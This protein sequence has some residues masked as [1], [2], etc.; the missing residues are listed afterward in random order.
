MLGYGFKP[1]STL[2]TSNSFDYST[3]QE[4]NEIEK[5]PIPNGNS[6]NISENGVDIS[7]DLADYSKASNNLEQLKVIRGLLNKLNDYNNQIQPVDINNPIVADLLEKVNNYNTN[8]DYL[9]ARDYVKNSVVSK[10]NQ[11]ISS[12]TNQVMATTPVDEPVDEWKNAV[13]LNQESRGIVKNTLSAY[14]PLS[15]FKQ[16]YDAAVGKDDVGISANGLKVLFAE[17]SYY[18]NYFRNSFDSKNL[19]FDNHTFR[20]SFTVDGISYSSGAIS[21]VAISDSQ[22]ADLMNILQLDESA[23]RDSDAATYLSGF[24]SLATDNA[25]ELLMA[26]VNAS[27]ELASMH[28]YLM[29]LGLTPTNIVNIM[30]SP[31]VEEV[32]NNMKDDIF[33]SDSVKLV[34][35]II[36]NLRKQYKGDAIMLENIKGFNSIYSGA[37]EIKQL[38]KLLGSNQKISANMQEINKFLTTFETIIFTRENNYFGSSLKSISDGVATKKG[39]DKKAKFFDK[40]N[41]TLDSMVKTIIDNSNKRFTENDASE[42]KKILDRVRNVEVEIIDNS[43]NKVKRTVSVLGGEFDFRYYIHPTNGTYRQATKDYY[44]LIK[45]TFNIF[46]IIDTV[47]HFKE[48][49]GGL[50]KSHQIL[51]M[52][53]FKYNSAFNLLKDSVREYGDNIANSANDSVKRIMGNNGLPVKIEDSNMLGA[54]NYV[55]R[56]MIAK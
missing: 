46:D 21:D 38:A 19:Q 54:S 8:T 43:G 1:N 13:K 45:D 22:K 36:S 52:S 7:S 30:T 12:P 48:L 17:M 56:L 42:I 47:P 15:F 2:D 53:S 40:F 49:I 39:V 55:D 6:T 31:I 28:I 32:V 25:K 51:S 14:S 3:V 26:K 24:V 50:V 20:K 23:F 37:Q 29:I 5:M 11:I 33:T 4:L 18:N 27:A 9:S 41:V 44:N 34:P 35:T 10:L 16:Q